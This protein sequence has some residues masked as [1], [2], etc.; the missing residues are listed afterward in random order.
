MLLKENEQQ[1]SEWIRENRSLQAHLLVL[2]RAN[3][4]LTRSMNQMHEQV[5]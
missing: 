2:Q 1:I 5:I 3:E 4:E